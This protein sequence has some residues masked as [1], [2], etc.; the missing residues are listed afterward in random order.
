MPGGGSGCRR[1]DS[2]RCQPQATGTGA[3]TARLN[4]ASGPVPTASAVWLA[5][6]PAGEGA[7]ARLADRCGRE[8]C[9]GR[10]PRG[11]ELRAAEPCG[12]GPCGTGPC[13]TGPCGPEPCGAEPRGPDSCG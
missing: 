13:G 8:P 2:T 9:G 1:P 12:T 3:E 10:E 5:A 4:P 11:S 7:F 6:G